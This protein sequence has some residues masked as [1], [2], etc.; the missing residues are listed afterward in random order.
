MQYYQVKPQYDNKTR[1]TRN[2]KGQVVRNGILIANE[3]YTPKEYE[4]LMKCPTWFE[5][6]E[7]PKNEIY[8]FFGARF[9]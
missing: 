5:L 8:F 3:L 2:N 4:K 6:V 7:I 9:A 1:Y